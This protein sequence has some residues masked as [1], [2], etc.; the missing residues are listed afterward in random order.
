M[1][2]GDP[3]VYV[4]G[5]GDEHA[6]LTIFIWN[7]DEKPMLNLV[8]VSADD[9]AADHFGRDREIKTSVAHKD[10]AGPGCAYWKETGK[11]KDKQDNKK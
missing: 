10:A 8:F 11:A 6:A 5:N 9:H 3:V 4:D 7:T 2:I 1:K